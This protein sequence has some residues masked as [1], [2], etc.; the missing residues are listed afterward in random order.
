MTASIGAFAAMGAAG[1]DQRR[2]VLDVHMQIGLKAERK[3]LAP[4]AS[5]GLDVLQITTHRM[6]TTLRGTT[7]GLSAQVGVLG[8]AGDKLMYRASAGYLGAIVPGTG[9]DLGGW[10]L[11]IG[12]GWRIDD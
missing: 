9:E 1:T 12:V 8:T 2:D 4:Y 6:D 5:V 7:L 10:M 3:T 11:Q